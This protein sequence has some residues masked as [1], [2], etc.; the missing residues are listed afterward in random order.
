MTSD[1]VLKYLLEY[2]FFYF[3]K[4]NYG[5]HIFI[6]SFNTDSKTCANKLCL[7]ILHIYMYNIYTNFSS[8]H[9]YTTIQQRYFIVMLSNIV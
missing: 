4:S 6:S 1:E 2:L 8:I 5:N 7:Q 3:I 9:N